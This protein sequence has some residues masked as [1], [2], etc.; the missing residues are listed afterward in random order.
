MSVPQGPIY[1]SKNQKLKA[2]ALHLFL[3]LAKAETVTIIAE[4]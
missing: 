3:L 2:D 4:D 1:Y